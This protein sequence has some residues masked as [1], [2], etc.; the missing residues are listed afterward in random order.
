MASRPARKTQLPYMARFLTA[1]LAAT[2]TVG[3]PRREK[4][5]LVSTPEGAGPLLFCGFVRLGPTTCGGWVISA[6][7]IESRKPIFPVNEPCLT[8]PR[9]HGLGRPR[10]HTSPATLF[11]PP[12]CS[13]RKHLSRLGD[14]GNI[15]YCRRTGGRHRARQAPQAR[16]GYPTRN[17]PTICHGG[18][19]RESLAAPSPR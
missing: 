19:H 14:C 4:R 3:T 6:L 12:D 1:P 7:T 18:W 2:V 10:Q 13:P 8:H 9:T 15:S 5:P 17:A 11:L 16:Q